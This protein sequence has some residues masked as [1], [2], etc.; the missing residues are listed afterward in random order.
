MAGEWT[1][2]PLGEDGSVVDDKGCPIVQYVWGQFWVNNHAHVLTGARGFTVEHLYTLAQGINVLPFVTGAVQPK[3]S[4]GNLKRIPIVLAPDKINI[5]FGSVILP[6]FQ[7][8]KIAH[9]ESTKLATLRD[10][11]L[12]NLLSGA[13]RVS[14]HSAGSILARSFAS[15]ERRRDHE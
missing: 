15:R 5:T 13:V 8:L 6:L 12:P 14:A 3:I 1:Q 10:Y 9:D 11:L 2:V 4:Q 7:R